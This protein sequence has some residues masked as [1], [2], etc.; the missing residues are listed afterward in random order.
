M[1]TWGSNRSV[2][3]VAKSWTHARGTAAESGATRTGRTLDSGVQSASNTF[4]DNRATFAVTLRSTMYR[5]P[6][7]KSHAILAAT[8]VIAAATGARSA[9]SPLPAAPLA[10]RAFTL[11]FDPAG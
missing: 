3:T 6:I 7:S 11:Q 4:A 2:G 9:Q 5:R 8:V 10:M 1:R